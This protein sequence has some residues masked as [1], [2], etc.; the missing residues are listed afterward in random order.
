MI[1][2]KE[3]LVKRKNKKKQKKRKKN[4]FNFFCDIF[5]KINSLIFGECT[6][7]TINLMAIEAS[8]IKFREIWSWSIE[9]NNIPVAIVI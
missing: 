4:K 5:L 9:D 2:R 3:N 6:N 7:L 8:I 1:L